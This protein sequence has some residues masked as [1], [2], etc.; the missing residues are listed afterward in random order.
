METDDNSPQRSGGA[1]TVV[2]YCLGALVVALVLLNGINVVARYIFLTPIEWAE[3]I[4]VFGMAW[5]VF[6]GAALVTWDDN[7]IRVDV[8]DALLPARLQR[9][10]PFV[11]Y[12]GMAI[13]SVVVLTQSIQAV[14][15]I[16]VTN[17]RTALS[18]LPLSALHLALP[19]GFALIGT[20][21]ILQIVRRARRVNKEDT[22]PG[23]R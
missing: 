19:V 13:V 17:Q 3:E 21:A 8:A 2:Q 7:H 14:H 23:P 12:A 9:L 4:I 20:I 16:I 6:V 5:T 18:G 10:R 11:L 15:F 1:E 22:R